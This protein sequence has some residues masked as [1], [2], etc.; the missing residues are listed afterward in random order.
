MVINEK[1]KN[2]ELET[3]VAFCNRHRENIVPKKL[4]PQEALGKFCFLS[5]LEKERDKVM[6][7]FLGP[8]KENK[9][10]IHNSF[11]IQGVFKVADHNKFN[12]ALTNG[13]GSRKSYGYGLILIKQGGKL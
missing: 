9:F 10:N 1:T 13:V 11:C 6:C 8:H 2:I 12:Q 3:H 7:N 4:Y 5:G